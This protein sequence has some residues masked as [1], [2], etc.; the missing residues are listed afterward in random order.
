MHGG[1]QFWLAPRNRPEKAKV[2][3]YIETP[4]RLSMVESKVI[5]LKLASEPFL[6]SGSDAVYSVMEDRSQSNGVEHDE[7]RGVTGEL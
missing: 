2:I 6:G 7:S 3:T 4:E 1:F 5:A